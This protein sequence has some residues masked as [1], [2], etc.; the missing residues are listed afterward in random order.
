M[1]PQLL[2]HHPEAVSPERDYILEVIL[3]DFLG[4]GFAMVAAPG[5]DIRISVP[6]SA[7]EL[8]VP[9]VFLSTPGELWLT[10]GS[11]PRQPLLSVPAPEELRESNALVPKD[12]LVLFGR[13]APTA[14]HRNGKSASLS[15][16]IFGSAFFMLSRYEEL[17]TGHRDK[18]DRFPGSAALAVREG[19]VERPV[20]NEWV[21]VLW[22]ALHLVWP[23]LRRAIAH[24][25]V[26]LSH[27]VDEVSLLGRP[28]RT[29]L[30]TIGADLILRHEPITAI[31]KAWAWTWASTS[32]D[33]S[34]LDPY[35][36]FDFIMDVSEANNLKS[37][38]FF[39]PG[40]SHP[41]DARYSLQ[42]NWIRSLMR[43]MAARGHEIGYHASY[44][45]Y[46]DPERTM[47]ECS[48]LRRVCEEEGIAQ[49][50]RG[51]RQHY[52]RWSNPQ[53][54]QNWENCGLEYDSTLTFAEN[55]GFRTG[56]CFSY[57]VWNLVARKRLRLRER[58]LIV[59]ENTLL[60][61]QNMSQAA[62]AAK[63]QDLAA[64]VRAYGGQF[65][66]LWHNSSLA[67]RIARRN[68]ADI[69]AS[70]S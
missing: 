53:T 34:T 52:L 1:T 4:L 62:A 55:A 33:I 9:E 24:Y 48:L 3:R 61:Y 45:T 46:L 44:N 58:P 36:C 25:E 51:G 12:I 14:F 35:N 29:V 22:A 11:M 28:P 31:R 5:S 2:V 49:P 21:E 50:V 32:G 7:G 6:G 64:T 65:T 15:V 8:I 30:R 67:A 57:P 69:V 47:A 39:I 42:D 37:A 54:W 70:V 63:A 18:F 17:A 43:K 26:Y 13:H 16:D 19:F 27:D 10:P 66:L 60:G 56:C 41:Y 59:M 40:N 38:F 68:Y 20:V 23:N